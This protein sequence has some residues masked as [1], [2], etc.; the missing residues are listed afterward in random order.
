VPETIYNTYFPSGILS[1]NIIKSSIPF[2]HRISTSIDFKY[3][4]FLSCNFRV[5][6]Y[7]SS[8]GSFMICDNTKF[9]CRFLWCWVWILHI[10]S[11]NTAQSVLIEGDQHF[12]HVYR[13]HHQGNDGGSKQKLCASYIFYIQQNIS[14]IKTAYFVTH[15]IPYISEAYTVSSVT[16]ISRVGKT[17][18]MVRDKKY[19]SGT[20]WCSHQ[21]SWQSVNWFKR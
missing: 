21:V 17:A 14:K 18:I 9:T 11:W 20:A 7:A 1:G 16:L 13:L 3:V 4:K 19:K 6:H 2:L 8:V 15:T 12:R 5:S 10:A